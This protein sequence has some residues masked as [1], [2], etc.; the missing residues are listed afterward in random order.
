MVQLWFPGLKFNGFTLTRGT[1]LDVSLFGVGLVIPPWDITLLPELTFWET[2]IIF[3]TDWIT[4][5]IGDAIATIPK[6]LI[7]FI[8]GRLEEETKA[9]YEAHPERKPE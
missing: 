8:T 7:D 4:A 9:Y 1:L 6:L 2:F 3:D 5:P